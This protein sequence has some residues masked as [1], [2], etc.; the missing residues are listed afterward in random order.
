MIDTKLKSDASS[1]EITSFIMWY[2]LTIFACGFTI[3]FSSFCTPEYVVVLV[4]ALYLTLA[5]CSNFLLNH[6][7]VKDQVIDNPLPLIWKTVRYT[8]K[9]RHQWQ[10]IL[11]VGEHGVLSKFNIAKTIYA[12]PFTSDQV[13]DVKAFFRVVG[14]IAILIIACSG[15]PTLNSVLNVL[16]AHF[17]S[18][19]PSNTSLSSCYK[20]LSVTYIQY[21][22]LLGVVLT[23]KIII[24]PLCHKCIPKINITTKVLV[25]ILLFLISVMILLGIESVSYIYHHQ[26]GVNQ[27]T[28]KC[29][30]QNKHNHVDIEFYWITIPNV[31]N[32][33]SN[34]LF[35]FSGIEFVSAQAPFNM[36]GLILGIAYALF[37]LATLVQA[38]IAIPFLSKN[39]AWEKAPLTC[40]IWYFIIQGVIV[41]VGFTVVVVM[42]KGYKRRDRINASQRE[43]LQKDMQ[44]HVESVN[45]YVN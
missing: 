11:T 12:G 27:T 13:E 36:K 3:Q 29:I 9:N 10:R 28:I 2:T 31:L 42:I 5:L 19:F 1:T 4:V 17:Q 38:A 8:I 6:W 33:L 41:L 45:L 15:I 7:L 39:S 44:I 26:L 37:G 32:V 21:I 16:M 30:F 22:F 34:F 25:S 24:H 40:G 18:W 14:V 35:I 43:W 20:R 23:Y